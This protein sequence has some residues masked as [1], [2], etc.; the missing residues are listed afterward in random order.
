KHGPLGLILF[1]SHTDTWDEYWGEKY[2]HGTSFLRALE[3]GLIDAEKSTMIGIR[4]TTYSPDDI[5][6]TR[7]YGLKVITSDEVRHYGYYETVK[8]AKER[9]KGAKAFLSFDIDFLD[10]VY[11]PGTG[12]PE[13]GGFTSFDTLSF[14]RQLTDIDFVGFDVVEVLP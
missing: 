14:L 12:T 11:A 1:D 7:S 10:P 9:I 8:I 3:E 13:I 4:G 6:K 5:E 2:T